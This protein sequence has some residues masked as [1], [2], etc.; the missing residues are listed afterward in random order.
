MVSISS[1]IVEGAGRNSNKEFVRFLSIAQGS[2]YERY[3][4]LYLCVELN[5]LTKEALEDILERITEIQKM[6]YVFQVFLTKASN[7]Y[8]LTSKSKI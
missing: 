8:H 3:T 1:N 2:S 6:N 4:Q 5:L 7:I